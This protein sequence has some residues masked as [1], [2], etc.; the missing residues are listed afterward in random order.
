MSE[1]L[2]RRARQVRSRVAVR[3]WEYRQRNLSKGV[4]FRLRRVL[5][6]AKEA[7]AIGPESFD[8]LVAEGYPREAVGDELA[9][10]PPDRLRL[11]GSAGPDRG[12]AGDPHFARRRFLRR[13][14]RSARPL[15]GPIAEVPA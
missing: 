15:P 12:T 14:G 10:A 8:A 13:A 4:W 7:W 9:P 3:A 1:S 5:A 6:E 2:A 11:R